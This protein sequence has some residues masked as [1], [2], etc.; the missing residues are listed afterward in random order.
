[1]FHLFFSVRNTKNNFKVRLNIR[2]LRCLKLSSNT[3]KQH[4]IGKI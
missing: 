2:Y 4:F 1:M 3:L